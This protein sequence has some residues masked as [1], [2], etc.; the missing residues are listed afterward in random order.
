MDLA[1]EL[2]YK[3]LGHTG[4]NPMVGA[5]IVKNQ[6]LIA[7][8]YHQR[9]GGLHAEATAIEDALSKGLGQELVGSTMYVTL[10]PCNHFGKTPPCTEKIISVGIEKVVVGYKDPNPDVVG[11]GMKRLKEASVDVVLLEPREDIKELY[12]EYTKQVLE[13]RPFVVGKFAMSLDGKIATYTG[14]SK[15]ITSQ[16]SRSYGHELRQRYQG[17]MVGIETVLKDDPML[18]VRH[19]KFSEACAAHPIRIVLDSKGRI[20]ELSQLVTSAKDIKTIV[21]TTK[22]MSKD[23]K[24]LLKKAQ[25]EVLLS[26]ENDEGRIDMEKLMLHLYEKGIGSILI[27]GGGQVLFS[28]LEAGLMDKIVGFIAPKL[29]GGAHAP[30]PFSGKGFRSLQEVPRIKRLRSWVKGEDIM[31]QGYI[32]G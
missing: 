8:G 28:A 12:E 7:T 31:I 10:E 24:E 27:E 3:G 9:Y 17:I 13:A 14:D 26:E 15:W 29:I 18:T 22:H 1:I 21:A 23:K 30:T 32:E 25:V 2:A 11:Q 4:S 6:E 19:E 5:V 16:Q 20:N